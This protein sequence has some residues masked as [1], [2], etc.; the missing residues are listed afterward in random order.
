MDLAWP[1]CGGLGMQREISSCGEV[2]AVCEKNHPLLRQLPT[3][4]CVRGENSVL[5]VHHPAL[6]C[7]EFR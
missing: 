2:A 4:P 6:L 7:V 5:A 3:P 1:A